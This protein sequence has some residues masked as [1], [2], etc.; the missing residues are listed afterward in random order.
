M[1]ETLK[2]RWKKLKKQFKQSNKI[3]KDLKKEIEAVEK[4]QTGGIHEMENVVK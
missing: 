1:R 3:V 4:T 2:W